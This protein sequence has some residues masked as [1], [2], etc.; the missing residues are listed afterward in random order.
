MKTEGSLH[1]QEGELGRLRCR[2]YQMVTRIQQLPT[3]T[4]Q[5]EHVRDAYDEDRAV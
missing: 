1:G 3:R 5:S 4:A 2:R